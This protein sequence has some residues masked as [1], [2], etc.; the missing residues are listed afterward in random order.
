MKGLKSAM[1]EMNERDIKRDIVGTLMIVKN[2]LGF[3]R[4]VHD[5]DADGIYIRYLDV[6]DNNIKEC[7]FSLNTVKPINGRIGM[8]NDG[9]GGV[10]YIIRNPG[11]KMSIGMN[12][13]NASITTVTQYTSEYDMEDIRNFRN[14]GW[15]EAFNG[16]YPT[17]SKALGIA[18]KNNSGCAFDKQF[19]VDSGGIIYYKNKGMVGQLIGKY[20]TVKNISWFP[21]NEHL[22]I[23]LENDY[24]KTV[25]TFQI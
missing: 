21:G 20:K 10:Y 16:T 15:I 9:N 13:G 12:W 25:R 11:R 8:V 3:I 7:K 23:I 6:A 5:Y 22:A 24:E 4:S 2:T 17:L 19:A 14:A 1:A 18:K